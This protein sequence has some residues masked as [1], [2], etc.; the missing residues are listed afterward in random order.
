MT[1]EIITKRLLVISLGGKN[2]EYAFLLGRVIHEGRGVDIV[3][4]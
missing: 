3:K 4:H 1:N 2:A